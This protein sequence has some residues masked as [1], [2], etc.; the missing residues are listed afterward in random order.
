MRTL[1]RGRA[2]CT[3]GRC[4]R[5]WGASCGRIQGLTLEQAI[6]EGLP[7]D[8]KDDFEKNLK[9]ASSAENAISY[10]DFPHLLFRYRSR[11]FGG[12]FSA[13]HD[14][15]RSPARIRDF[16]NNVIEHGDTSVM[17]L[18]KTI[19]EMTVI[20][21]FMAEINDTESRD[22][23]LSRCEEL[24]SPD[25]TLIDSEP[26]ETAPTEL[27]ADD[28]KETSNQGDADG[29][30]QPGIYEME[31]EYV[32]RSVGKDSNSPYFG[33]LFKNLSTDRTVWSNFSLL[34]SARHRLLW[35]MEDF[36]VDTQGVEEALDNQ[37]A[38]IRLHVKLMRLVG[39]TF[40]LE[41]ITGEFRNESRNEIR[42]WF[43]AGD[44]PT[45]GTDSAES[46]SDLPF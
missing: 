9:T 20:A 21:D 26:T 6:R 13:N 5:L 4:V 37:D 7:A 34:P 3:D 27:P 28:S 35:F 16:R 2:M 24:R 17:T 14:S 23:I 44:D 43:G 12:Y 18:D 25:I 39:R 41:I 46:D 29:L 42:R 40:T 1:R 30:L 38:L 11:I 22:Q 19:E 15:L 10:G 33:M 32:H 8:R 36:G 45:K 31:L